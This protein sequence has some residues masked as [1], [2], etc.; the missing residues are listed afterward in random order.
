MTLRTIKL[1]GIL[2]KKFGKQ[3]TLDLYHFRDV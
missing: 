3:Y 1:G 2:G